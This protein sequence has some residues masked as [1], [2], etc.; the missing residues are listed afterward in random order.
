MGLLLIVVGPGGRPSR[1]PAANPAERVCLFYCVL[2]LIY[3]GSVIGILRYATAP[4]LLLTAF[5]GGRVAEWYR[6]SRNPVRPSILAAAV[7]CFAFAFC[8]VL[9]LDINMPQM[10]YFTRRLDKPGYL[11][12]EH[13]GYGSLAFLRDVAGPRDTVFAVGNC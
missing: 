3:W 7:Y 9:I 13:D 4:I 10:L 12:L 6:S 2:Y 1:N 8:G 11:R 5:C